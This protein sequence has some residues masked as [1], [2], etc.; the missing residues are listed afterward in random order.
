MKILKNLQKYFIRIFPELCWYFLAQIY[1]IRK[2]LILHKIS[3]LVT[4][5]EYL[6][7]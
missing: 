3:S 6:Q 1:V 5:L 4:K 2:Y 7:M